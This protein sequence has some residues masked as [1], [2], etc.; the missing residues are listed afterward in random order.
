MAGKQSE[1]TKAV[2]K[3]RDTKPHLASAKRISTSK[4]K[5][6]VLEILMKSHGVIQP[7]LDAANIHRSTYR[8]WLK[9]DPKFAAAVEATNE[10]A[11]DFVESKLYKNIEAGKEIST[12][13]YL[14][15]RAAHRGYYEKTQMD[16]TSGGKPI[17]FNFGGNEEEQQPIW[18]TIKDVNNE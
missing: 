18:L 8:D 7:A 5:K 16:I 6:I 15:T 9:K 3:K 11:I 14:K 2:I 1:P 10:A 12:I 13:F 4:K 17:N